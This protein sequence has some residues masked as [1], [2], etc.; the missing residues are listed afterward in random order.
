MQ[1]PKESN[2]MEISHSEASRRWRR[3]WNLELSIGKTL[4]WHHWMK[5]DNPVSAVACLCFLCI[6][7]VSFFLN[8]MF[9][10]LVKLPFF[11][12]SDF[13]LLLWK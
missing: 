11:S 13:F 7:F 6:S 4:H 5:L 1:T 9:K 3:N 8:F 12:V 2:N 10:L